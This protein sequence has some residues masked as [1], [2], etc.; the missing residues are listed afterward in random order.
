MLLVFL[1]KFLF[2]QSLG[3]AQHVNALFQL[4]LIEREKLGHF[5]GRHD[6]LV[7]K[8]CLRAPVEDF[9]ECL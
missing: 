6:V 8:G 5:K 7:E 9:V 3:G 2:A 1:L 4:D